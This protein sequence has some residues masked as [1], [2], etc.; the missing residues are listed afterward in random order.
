MFI[1]DALQGY[2]LQI[3][4]DGRSRHT[5]GQYR[6]HITVLSRWLARTGHPGHLRAI[7]PEDLAR[8]LT[9][10]EARLTRSGRP[11]RATSVNGL[12]SSLRGFFGYLHRA[13]FLSNDPARLIRRAITG[14]PPP[15]GLT[16]AEEMRFRRALAKGRTR[17]DR[18]DRVLFEL[19]LA[20]GV[21]LS[22]ALGVRTEDVDLEEGVVVVHTKGDK[23]QRVFLGREIRR[24]LERHLEGRQGFLFARADGKA[25]CPRH[26]QRRFRRLRET[27]GLPFGISPHSLRHAFATRLYAR[28]HDVFVVK[29]ALGHQSI[30]STM[31]YARPDDVRLRRAVSDLAATP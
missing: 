2:L 30:S 15:R 22:A 23:V 3:E 16:D 6:R 4:A 20:T 7:G 1:D 25:L 10:P 12:R 28:T 18:R 5:A 29:E 19:M 8:F 27:A 9:A 31:A 13:G 17:E 24:A 21:R 26:V 14:P 11:K